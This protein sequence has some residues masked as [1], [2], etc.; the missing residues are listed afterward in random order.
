MHVVCYCNDCRAF[1]H[2]LGRADVLDQFG[3]TELLITTPSRLK[4]TS[5]FEN[6]RCLR[7]SEKGLLR[8]HWGCCNTPL[9]NTTAAPGLPFVSIHR[10]F[11]DLDNTNALGPMK[12][13]FARFA[14]GSPPP[15]AE[16]SQSPTTIIKIMSFLFMARLYGAHR[17]NPLFVGG[18]P[19]VTPHILSTIERNALREKV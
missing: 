19:T 12:R 2:A 18:K 1:I 4:L 15:G 7:L 13:V 8:W 3:G 9:A 6:L 14:I 11:I 16:P 17:P 5:G 10:A